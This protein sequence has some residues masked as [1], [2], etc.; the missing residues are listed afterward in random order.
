MAVLTGEFLCPKCQAKLRINE[1]GKKS[2]Q[3]IC[4]ECNDPI[5]IKLSSTGN[6]IAFLPGENNAVSTQEDLPLWS[7]KK[8]DNFPMLLGGIAIIGLILMGLWW[9]FSKNNDSPVKTDS[10]EKK[11]GINNSPDLIDNKRTPTGSTPES[12]GKK[13]SQVESPF[14]QNLKLLGQQVD[15]YQHQHGQFPPAL[16]MTEGK[17]TSNDG[18]FSWLAGLD[19]ALAEDRSLLPQWNLSWRDP[20]NDRFVRRRRKE[21]LNPA[22][23]L[24]ASPDRYPA[25]H[26]VGIAGVGH[27]APGLPVSDPRAGI[28][29]I[30]RSTKVKDVTDG[31]SNTMLAAGVTGKLSSWADGSASFRPVVLEP[32]INGPDGF[33]SGQKNGMY[34]LM[35]DGSV[36]FLN[37]KTE[38][39]IIRRMAA[40]ADALPLDASVPGEPGTKSIIIATST[41]GDKTEKMNPKTEEPPLPTTD[42]KASSDKKTP[43]N[44]PKPNVKKVPKVE[45]VPRI[46]FEKALSR[47]VLQFELTQAAPLE[48]VLIELEAMI[49][50]R[51]EFDQKQIPTDDAIRQFKVSFSKRNV[52]FKEL[53]AELIKPAELRYEIRKEHIAILKKQ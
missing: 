25:S 37:K 53:L 9:G 21:L 2:A 22:I 41:E 52:S 42:K 33:G 13:E 26:I 12:S 3:I 6:L 50:V 35:A 38:P 46:D 34:V 5:Q 17:A 10:A 14:A 32:Y 44:N 18:R 19:P 31:L 4:P 24:Q 20:L 45:P 16:W 43:L 47:K 11:N 28:F 29:G 30:N 1:R 40:I 7:Q 27:D 15:V 36:R 23:R 39:T 8:P 48:T 49:G 51:I